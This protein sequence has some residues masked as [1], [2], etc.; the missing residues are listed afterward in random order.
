MVAYS[1]LCLVGLNYCFVCSSNRRDTGLACA[2]TKFLWLSVSHD[3]SF[4]IVGVIFPWLLL[5]AYCGIS[6][7]GVDSI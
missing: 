5:S 6:L 3:S 2:T 1:R 4:L 7:V